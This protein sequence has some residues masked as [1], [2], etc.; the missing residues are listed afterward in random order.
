ME[1]K[2]SPG[3]ISLTGFIVAIAGIIVSMVGIG[4]FSLVEV[5]EVL[6]I[7]TSLFL[8]YL[9]YVITVAGAITWT[10]GIVKG[11]D[12]VAEDKTCAGL[13]VLGVMPFIAGIITLFGGVRYGGSTEISLAPG[14]NEPFMSVKMF[15]IVLGAIIAVVG[16]AVWGIGFLKSKVKT[17]IML[18]GS[19]TRAKK[20]RDLRSELKKISWLSWRDTYR[21]SGI[22]LVA[23]VVVAI[24]V[25]L[26]DLLFYKTLNDW[27]L[28][29]IK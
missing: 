18:R 5:G 24:V 26:I 2:K 10:V 29:L 15:L 17:T 14:T 23:L 20:L 13:R 3:V 27:I 19:N 28:G 22:V 16:L 8:L 1:N 4:K 25:G 6:S 7:P 9:G 12:D 21:Q 11:W